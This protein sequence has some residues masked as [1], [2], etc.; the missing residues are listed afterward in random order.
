MNDSIGANIYDT[1]YLPSRDKEDT[2]DANPIILNKA[3]F[4][5]LSFSLSISLIFPFNCTQL[6]KLLYDMAFRIHF[7]WIELYSFS[8]MEEKRAYLDNARRSLR[9]NRLHGK[10]LRD[11]FE[12]RASC[13]SR[14][15]RIG[16]CWNASV[17]KIR[18]GMNNNRI[19]Y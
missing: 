18:I 10:P 19:R 1:S 8:Q 11:F 2:S 7:I 15:K 3:M 17:V 13:F 16:E 12:V 5:A 14:R 6:C 9:E 4:I